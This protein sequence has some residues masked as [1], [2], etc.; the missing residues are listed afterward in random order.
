MLI[1][2]RFVNSQ[3]QKGPKSSFRIKINVLYIEKK[4][5]NSNSKLKYKIFKKQKYE[6]IIKFTD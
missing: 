4:I 1:K 6:V 5:I 3:T 2:D